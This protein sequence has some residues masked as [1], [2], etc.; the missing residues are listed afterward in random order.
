MSTITATNGVIE[1]GDEWPEGTPADYDVSWT[2]DEGTGYT[3]TDLTMRVL[4]GDGTEIEAES[5]LT[6]A[7]TVA[8]TTDAATNDLGDDDSGLRVIVLDWTAETTRHPA[9]IA[10]TCE[11]HYQVKD[12]AGK[13]VSS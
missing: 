7:A 13:P 11:I 1:T 2:D 8:V 5:E 3:P 9:G 12:M 6:E 4:D 10:Q